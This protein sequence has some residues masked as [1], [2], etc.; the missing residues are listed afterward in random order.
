MSWLSPFH[1]REGRPERIKGTPLGTM[2]GGDPQD[3]GFRLL[4]R[5]VARPS[6]SERGGYPNGLTEPPWARWWPRGLWATPSCCFL[7]AVPRCPRPV[8]FAQRGLG[9][10]T[11]GGRSQR[12]NGK[13][14]TPSNGGA[15]HMDPFPH[16]KCPGVVWGSSAAFVCVRMH[17]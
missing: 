17:I 3:D 9:R 2:M 11:C 12:G 6:K 15:A 13:G 8:G 16:P 14:A 1:R 10:K 4:S 7:R 5:T